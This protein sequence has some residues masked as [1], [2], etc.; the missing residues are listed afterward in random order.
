MA[1]LIGISCGKRALWYTNTYFRGGSLHPPWFSLIKKKGKCNLYGPFST[2]FQNEMIEYVVLRWKCI[3]G[4][5]LSLMLRD[6]Y[7]TH[8]MTCSILNYI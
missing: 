8:Q 7:G 1:K 6:Y 5:A 3:K 4:F 2:E